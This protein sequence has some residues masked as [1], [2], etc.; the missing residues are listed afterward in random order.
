MKKIDK[1]GV[2]ET[3]INYP[4]KLANSLVYVLEGKMLRLNL[5][6]NLLTIWLFY[7]PSLRLIVEK[8]RFTESPNW[9]TISALDLRSV[10]MRSRASA[11]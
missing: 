7:D 2:V 3:R 9:L 6:W 10:I 1:L 5:T 4:S 8:K 11:R